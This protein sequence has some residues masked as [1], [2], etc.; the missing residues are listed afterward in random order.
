M[1]AITS[2]RRESLKLYK[3]LLKVCKKFNWVNEKGVLW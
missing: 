2:T 3:D 1:A